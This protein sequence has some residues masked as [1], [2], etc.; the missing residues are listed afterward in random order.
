MD[1]D[2]V[3]ELA[4]S[5]P[6]AVEYDHGGRPSFRVQGRPR[7]ASGL[8]QNGI[9]LMPGEVAIREAVAEWPEICTEDWHGRRLVSVRVAYP[10]LP[11]AVVVELVTEAWAYRAPAR[12]VRAY[13]A[14][15]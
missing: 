11:D 10:R 3:R 5:C 15:R 4:L 12:L 7:F 9:S 6:G 8:D 1:A 14:G 13:R 2:Q